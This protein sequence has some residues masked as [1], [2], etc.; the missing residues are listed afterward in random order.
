V[1]AVTRLF[2]YGSLLASESNHEVLA[3]ATFVGE[4]RTPS[5]FAL[6]DLGAY[7]AMIEGG[8]H[9]VIGEV[10]EVDARV[11]ARVDEYEGH[12]TLFR[13]TTIALDD[14]TCVETYL[15]ANTNVAGRPLIASGSW[16]ARSDDQ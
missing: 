15:L 1:K 5:T 14:G 11:L 16:R 4:A 8:G 9:A 2:V 7:P 12:P 13:R 6:H 10:Y 3:G